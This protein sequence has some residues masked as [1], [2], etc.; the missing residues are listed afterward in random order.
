MNRYKQF[1]FTVL[2]LI[3]C[4]CA[5]P[6]IFVKIW[7]NSAE[8]KKAA[9]TPPP[10]AV[11]ANADV[12]K[13]TEA[14]ADKPADQ[15]QE[16]TEAPQE[17]TAAKSSSYTFEKADI[18]YFSDALFIGDS[19]T[20]GLQEYGIM[21]DVSEFFCTSGMATSTVDSATVSG[22]TLNNLLTSVKYG[23]IYLM[24]GINEV[25]NNFDTTISNYK[26]I[27]DNLKAKQPDAI[28]YVMGNLHVAASAEQNGITNAN[29][30]YL[31]GLIEG[32]ADND[33]VYYLDANSE[34][35]DEYGALNESYSGDGIHP[36]AEY[37]KQWS[38]WIRDNTVP[39]GKT[40]P[41]AEEPAQ[42][43][44]Q[45]EDSADTSEEKDA[46]EKKDDTNNEFFTHTDT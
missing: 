1:L 11:E 4:F 25:A 43:E 46:P 20:V 7:K 8:E 21:R 16:A 5:S 24:I 33:R 2:L 31:N 39:D 41:P 42:D 9:A 44:A 38:E 22:H 35:D 3:T 12:Q 27:V 37:Y 19:R 28:I 23:K 17:D 26:N 32:L 36:K 29:I 10:A 34:F 13:A 15:Q 18:S 30:N 45:P 6:F 14:A 40:P